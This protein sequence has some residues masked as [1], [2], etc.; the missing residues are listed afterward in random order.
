VRRQPDER[1]WRFRTVGPLLSGLILLAI[2]VACSSPSSSSPSATAPA[3]AGGAT[4]KPAGGAAQTVT[5][6]MTDANQ[7][8]PATITIPRGSTVNWSNTSQT[9]HSVT[10]DASKAATASDA[11]LPSGAQP[12]DSGFLNPAAT[13]SRT[14]DTPGSYTYFC[15]PHEALGMIA[16]I[17]VT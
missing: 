1:M 2:A 5:V 14:F 6:N 9:V 10:D 17:T 15:I 16:K 3:G 13:F 7:F 11:V 8:Q 12:W 4:T